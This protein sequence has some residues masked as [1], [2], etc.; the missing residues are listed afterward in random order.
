[1]ARSTV[2]L[3]TGVE[4]R[5]GSIRIRFSRNGKRCSETLPYPNTSA[6]IAAASRLRDQVI[7]LDKLG[8][9]DEAKYTELFP[10]STKASEDE[11]STFGQYAQIWLDSRE[12]S[13]GTR[14]NYK[15]ALNYWWMPKLATIPL[16]AITQTLMRKLITEIKWSSPSVKS[17]AMSKLIT[18]FSSAVSDGLM[19]KHPMKDL[20]LPKKT[21]KKVD[22]FTK[23]EADQII[24]QLYADEDRYAQ[25]Y[26]AFFEFAFYTGI[27][28]GE[29]MALRWT[30]IDFEKKTAFICRVVAEGKIVERTKTNQTRYVLLNDRA[31]HALQ[32]AKKYAAFREKD[33]RQQKEFHYCFPPSQGKGFIQSH[34]TLHRNWLPVLTKLGIRYRKPYAARH[35]YATMCLMS[36][37]NPAF[38][39][40]QLGHSMDMLLGTY[41]QWLSTED[42]WD[43]MKKLKVAPKLPQE[44]K[45]PT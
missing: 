41:A 44:R 21:K 43:Q 12:I 16:K 4:L 42:D 30:E 11:I 29:I 20:E 24:K 3:P 1:M 33:T 15:S 31:I 2:A 13:E 28:L 22:P 40:K 37:M 38:I 35:T 5:G 32:F 18:I 45:P 14:N 36:G 39:A 25:I 8:L 9:L 10:F 26:G 19:E 23:E 6:G 34:T 27:R 17:S 7:N